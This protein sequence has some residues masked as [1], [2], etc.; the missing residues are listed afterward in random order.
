MSHPSCSQT[1]FPLNKIG[2][3]NIKSSPSTFSPY[4]QLRFSCPCSDQTPPTLKFLL[5][6]LIELHWLGVLALIICL[7]SPTN[8]SDLTLLQL[9][10]SL[11]LHLIWGF[12]PKG[13]NHLMAPS[14]KKEQNSIYLDLNASSL[15]WNFCWRF[16]LRTLWNQVLPAPPST[17]LL[18]VRVH[19]VSPATIPTIKSAPLL[20]SP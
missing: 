3:Y 16:E 1:L 9:D 5:K 13:H 14:A 2:I 18:Y 4:A 17:L 11:H 15:L 6:L 10:S 19:Q 20:S 7:L 12:P 8:Q